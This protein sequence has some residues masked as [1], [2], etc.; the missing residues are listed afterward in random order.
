MAAVNVRLLATKASYDVPF[1]YTE[2]ETLADGKI[3]TTWMMVFTVAPIPSTSSSR[4]QNKRFDI[5]P[6]SQYIVIPADYPHI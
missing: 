6:V 2:R 3:I 4:P 1:S 5:S